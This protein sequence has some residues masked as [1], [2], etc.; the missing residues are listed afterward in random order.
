MGA[1][2]VFEEGGERGSQELRRFAFHFEAVGPAPFAGGAA[3]GSGGTEAPVP[4]T[5][6]QRAVQIVH[7]PLLRCSGKGFATVEVFRT[8]KGELQPFAGLHGLRYNE[9][10]GV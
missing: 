6:F 7:A 2:G 8:G 3:V 4:G 1:R 10:S 5:G 9:G